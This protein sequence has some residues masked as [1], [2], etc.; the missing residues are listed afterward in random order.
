MKIRLYTCVLIIFV[1]I[2]CTILIYVDYI[3]FVRIY[4]MK[5]KKIVCYVPGMRKANHVKK[6]PTKPFFKAGISEQKYKR[7]T[8]TKQ[9]KTKHD[10]NR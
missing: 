9:N 6:I 1:H 2:H 4:C 5:K 3:F 10:V 8:F 7:T